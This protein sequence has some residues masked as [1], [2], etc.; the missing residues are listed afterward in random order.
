MG[1][2]RHVR[3][4]SDLAAPGIVAVEQALGTWVLTV[5]GDEAQQFGIGS[6]TVAQGRVTQSLGQTRLLAGLQQPLVGGAQVVGAFVRLIQAQVQVSQVVVG[7]DQRGH[8]FVNVMPA[9]E[10]HLCQRQ[11]LQVMFPGVYQLAL[12]EQAVGCFGRAFP[13]L[14]GIATPR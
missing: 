8:R 3:P 9:L 1:S 14:Q 10:Q 11:C 6:P 5:L 2:G 13:V 7:D 12:V 4:G